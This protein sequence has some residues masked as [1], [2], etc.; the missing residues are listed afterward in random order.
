MEIGGKVQGTGYYVGFQFPG[1]RFS[2]ALD[3]MFLYWK[4]LDSR[5]NGNRNGHLSAII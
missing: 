3:F 2:G 4:Q 5:E 1:S